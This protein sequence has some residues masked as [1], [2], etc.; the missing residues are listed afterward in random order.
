MFAVSFNIKVLFAKKLKMKC[1][2]VPRKKNETTCVTILTK[3]SSLNKFT[4]KPHVLWWQARQV[5]HVPCPHRTWSCET[6]CEVVAPWV[7][8]YNMIF[9][10]ERDDSFF[11]KIRVTI[12]G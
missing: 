6:I 1:P 9:W 4:K 7:I 5:T 12:S 2:L 10:T 11:F 3:E 8:M